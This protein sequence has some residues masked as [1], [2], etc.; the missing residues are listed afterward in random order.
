MRFCPRHKTAVIFDK[1][2][3]FNPVI[4]H[5]QGDKTIRST[6]EGIQEVL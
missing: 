6:N 2:S 3:C 1:E 4:I 5:L